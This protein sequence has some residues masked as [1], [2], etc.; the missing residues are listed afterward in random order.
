MLGV[1]SDSVAAGLS[2]IG[3]GSTGATAGAVFFAA[4][5]FAGFLA[6]LRAAGLVPAAFFF[7]GA[8]L[9]AFFFAAIRCLPF[10][11]CG[12][13]DFAALPPLAQRGDERMPRENPVVN[14]SCQREEA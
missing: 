6:A 10:I 8:F 2:E 11:V 12:R 7:A 9:V 3:G 1:D 13:L 5:V 4:I 14:H